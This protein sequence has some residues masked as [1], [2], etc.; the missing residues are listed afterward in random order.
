MLLHAQGFDLVLYGD[1]IT[2]FWRGTSGGLPLGC[3]G[4]N[5]KEGVS[6]WDNATYIGWD[7]RAVFDD[8]LAASYK[9]GVMAI[10]GV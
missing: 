8:T 5:S 1:S 7:M 10:A 4:C 2:E 9:S 3:T 6:N